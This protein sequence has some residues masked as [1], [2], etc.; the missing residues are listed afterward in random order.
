VNL[1]S[2]V[3][4]AIGITRFG[5][6]RLDRWWFEALMWAFGG[7]A[8]LVLDAVL[9]WFNAQAG[10]ALGLSLAIAGWVYF[11]VRQWAWSRWWG[12]PGR[13]LERHLPM[14]MG[15]LF[16]AGSLDE[17]EQRWHEVL[18]R[19]FEPLRRSTLDESLSQA[20]IDD[21]GQVLL[22]PGLVHARSIRLEHADAG[23]CLFGPS[24]RALADELRELARSAV[25][26]RQ[27]LDQREA[28][29][30]ARLREREAM[31]QEL[32]DGLGGLASNI[33]LAAGIAQRADSP[34]PV[35]QA[36]G[37]I[38]RLAGEA[39]SEIRGFMDSL[40]SRDADWGSFAADLCA[41]MG[42]RAEAQGL[43][44]EADVRIDPDAAAPAPALRLNLRRLCQE[45]VTNV[46]KHAGAR[47]VRLTLR[48]AGGRLHLAVADDGCGLGRPPAAGGGRSRGLEGM[49]RRARQLGG[50][51]SVEG[52]NGTTVTLAL[53]HLSPDPGMQASPDAR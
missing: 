50:T 37:T 4:L 2:F 17:L 24:E 51:L 16:G 3:G 26:A 43:V 46:V 41:A 33:A 23:R 42:R 29:R 14:L 20:R 15:G 8:V 5:L 10:L 25:T 13:T 52:N 19:V 35:R 34:A 21:E 49:R 31:V 6:F 18:G 32:H 27:A 39:L 30:E 48:V 38:E 7:A 12:V 53:P 47:H 40:D 11:P 22:V 44:F 9:L 45:A 28:E 36:L 1:L